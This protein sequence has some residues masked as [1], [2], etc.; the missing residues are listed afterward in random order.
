MPLTPLRYIQGQL[1]LWSNLT[2]RHYVLVVHVRIGSGNVT[3]AIQLAAI[4]GGSSFVD[5]LVCLMY[6][7]SY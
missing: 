1:A 2:Q 5:L 3:E 6:L 4:A 7:Y